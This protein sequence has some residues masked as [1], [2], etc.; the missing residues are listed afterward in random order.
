MA[1]G[2]ALGWLLLRLLAEHSLGI[3]RAAALVLGVVAVVCLVV[4]VGEG[5]QRPMLSP[6]MAYIIVLLAALLVA[7]MLLL[8]LGWR[9]VELAGRLLGVATKSLIAN[10]ALFLF[11]G[12]SWRWLLCACAHDASCQH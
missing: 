11:L 10:P 6:L 3:T 4:L 7:L 2:V 1:G 9:R 12:V 8:A 5:V